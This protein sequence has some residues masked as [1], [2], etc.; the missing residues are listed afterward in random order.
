MDEHEQDGRDA[1]QE[2]WA[3]QLALEQQQRSEEEEAKDERQQHEG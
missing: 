1:Q 2:A 3:H